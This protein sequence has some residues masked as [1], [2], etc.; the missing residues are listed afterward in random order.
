M[1]QKREEEEEKERLYLRSKTQ[2]GES[3]IWS[4][5]LSHYIFFEEY[6]T[7]G[8]SVLR[9]VL[10]LLCRFEHSQATLQL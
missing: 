2:S 9:S 10:R 6:N 4:T 8:V 5:V 7:G 3:A 1:C